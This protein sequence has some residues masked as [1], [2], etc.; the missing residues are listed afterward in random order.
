MRAKDW[1]AYW[2]NAGSTAEKKDGGPQ[3]EALERF[4]LKFFT[5]IY[6]ALHTGTRL[7]DIACGNGAVVRFARVAAEPVENSGLNIYG[8]D[9]SASAIRLMCKR[10]PGTFGIAAEA[11]LL[12]F[13]NDAFDLVMSQFG[14]E[15]A[16]PDAFNE[17]ARIIK[18]GGIFAAVLHLRDG[19]IYRECTANLEA[20]NGMRR[21]NLLSSF[22]G[23]FRAAQA[24]Q[25][26]L[27]GKEMFHNADKVFAGAVAASENV[28][29]HWGKGAADGMLFRI[30]SDI[31]HMYRRFRNYDPDEVVNWISLMS[32]D[33]DTFA[34]RMSSMLKAALD[35]PAVDRLI[36]QLT[37]GGFTVQTHEILHMGRLSVP[38]A[39]TVV[40]QKVTS[41][42][43]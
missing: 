30:Y 43:L 28:L 20:I 32:N 22:E 19:A 18:P 17:V 3:D 39:W 25:R 41:D 12:P 34:G 8:L 6:P 42:K 11:A 21:S 13:Q 35:A 37:S 26:G 40:A 27:G 2:R 38:A 9:V 31:A 10:Y 4:W 15:Y 16:G 23:L 14:V 1:D 24:V 33:L 29:Q 5:Q 36:A 7:L